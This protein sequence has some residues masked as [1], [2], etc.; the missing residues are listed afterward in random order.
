MKIEKELKNK[1]VN[2]QDKLHTIS[3][4]ITFERNE[5]SSESQS[6]IIVELLAKQDM[7]SNKIEELKTDLRI[8]HL[9]ENSQYLGC[10]YD[11]WMKEKKRTVTIVTRSE[12][13]PLKDLISLDSPLAQA[14]VENLHTEEFTMV[15]PAGEL[16]LKFG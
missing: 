9:E 11:I 7:I 12:A 16:L 5:R 10:S 3:E 1:I 13:D 14:I 4:Q 2:L 6:P 8:L 15:T